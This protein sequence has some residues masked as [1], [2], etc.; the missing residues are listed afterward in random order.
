MRDSFEKHMPLVEIKDHNAL[1]DNEPFFDQPVEKTSTNYDYTTGNLLY[2]L[3][4]QNYYKLNGID[5]LRQTNTNIPQQIHFP[6]KLE[7]DYGV[8]MFFIAEK[9]Q[10]SILN[11]SLDS[12]IVT[13]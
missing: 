8:V 11:M 7:K 10:K 4:C 5:L 2:Y 13:E 12:L 9:Q 6:R 3:H 1:T